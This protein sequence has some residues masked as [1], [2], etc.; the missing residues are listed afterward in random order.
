MKK[1]GENKIR[2]AA[3]EGGRESM[4]IDGKKGKTE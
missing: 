3:G 4:A 2:C 1:V